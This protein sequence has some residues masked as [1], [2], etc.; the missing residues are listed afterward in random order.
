[1]PRGDRTGPAGWGPMT[2]RRMGYCAGFN[3][4]GYAS[5]GPGMGYGRGWG[6]GMGWGR[7][8]AY[9]PAYGPGVPVGPEPVYARPEPEDE[10]RYLEQCSDELERE[11][12]DIKKRIK[13]LEEEK[14]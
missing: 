12:E 10:L 9:P 1:M 14:E 11:L 3:A 5:P 2:G 6:R 8:W 4:P 13:Q 7:R